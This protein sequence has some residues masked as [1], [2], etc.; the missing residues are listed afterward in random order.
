[1][2]ESSGRMEFLLPSLS[3]STDSRSSVL[4]NRRG[5]RYDCPVPAGG[6]STVPARKLQSHHWP[7]FRESLAR[8]I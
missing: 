6:Y 8:L 5:R 2:A 7:P 3:D 4:A 1:M